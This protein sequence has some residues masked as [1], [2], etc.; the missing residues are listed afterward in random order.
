MPTLP[1]DT[2]PLSLI[3]ALV[4][5][6]VT[7]AGV[8]GYLFKYFSGR[9]EKERK[10]AEAERIRLIEA[11][12]EERQN[13]AVERVRLEVTAK[14]NRAEY[15]IKHREVVERHAD[16]LER[17]YESAREH[18]NMARREY[19]ANMEVVA[20][21]AREVQE[22]VGAVLDKIYSRYIGMRRKD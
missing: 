5:A 22:K 20:E 6:V 1:S 9:T 7:M 15:E 21:K 19:A 4:V 16:A 8:I 2:N 12:A 13:W 17:L 10:S 18:E 11:H 14:E 3:A